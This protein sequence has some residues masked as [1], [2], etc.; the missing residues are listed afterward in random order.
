[1]S[2]IHDL[3]IDL[4]P[5]TQIKFKTHEE[6][7]F[8]DLGDIQNL[9]T[10]HSMASEYSDE[11]ESLSLFRLGGINLVDGTSLHFRPILLADDDDEEEG[12]SML[13]RALSCPPIFETSI[14]SPI[15]DFFRSTSRCSRDTS[16]T[17]PLSPSRVAFKQKKNLIL[18][19]R[20]ESV[21]TVRDSRANSP[22]DGDGF[23]VIPDDITPPSSLFFK[24]PRLTTMRC[25]AL[26]DQLA[27]NPKKSHEKKIA[28]KKDKTKSSSSSPRA[29][30][31]SARSTMHPPSF[32]SGSIASKIVTPRPVRPS[33]RKNKRQAVAF[34]QRSMSFTR[35]TLPPTTNTTTTSTTTVTTNVRS[36][37]GLKYLSNKICETLSSIGSATQETMISMLYKSFLTNS[38]GQLEQT[39]K[40]IRRRIYDT[41]NVLM[42]LGLVRKT[43][44]NIEWIG[45][46]SNCRF[47]SKGES[48]MSDHLTSTSMVER[49]QAVEKQIA[50]TQSRIESKK[51][52]LNEVNIQYVRT[53]ALLE[54]NAK[55]QRLRTERGDSSNSCEKLYF[56]FLIVKA[57]KKQ[58]AEIKVR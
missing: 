51:R 9:E 20:S 17:L 49:K 37:R 28:N 24:P 33:N 34:S 47:R 21:M 58:S 18:R 16:H 46:T 52:M 54:R 32:R 53:K 3:E 19:K 41:L 2:T 15:P 12:K 43:K 44:N 7:T 25:K 57:D 45:T 4:N 35:D 31:E 5:E 1:M 26:P 39:E 8:S 6:T 30:Q 36:M 13:S 50:E 56:P 29:K 40:S 23:P 55:R 42:A 11:D 27:L 22:P 48:S 38:N 10:P 14:N